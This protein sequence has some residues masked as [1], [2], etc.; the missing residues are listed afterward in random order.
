MMA[1][2]AALSVWVVV[3]VVLGAGLCFAADADKANKDSPGQVE[4]KALFE[5]PV[6][7]CDQEGKTILT[8]RAVGHP[9]VV[10]FNGDGRNDILLGCHKG[11]DTAAAEILVLENVG[12]KH[13]PKFRWPTGK[14]I[15][16][17]GQR[18]GFSVSC[19]CK[20]GG[21]F[22]LHPVDW[23]GDGHFDLVVN[24]Y[25]RS[26]G[27][28]VLRNTGRS[29]KDPTF[30]R[31]E[32]LH[33]IG[34]HGKCS[35]GGDWNNDGIVDF[36]FPVNRY[37]W[38]VYLG[39]RGPGGQ[40][41]FADKPA[42]SHRQYKMIGRDRWFEYSP[43]AWNYSGKSPVGAKTVEIIAVSDDPANRGKP[44]QDQVSHLD[45]Y[46]LD[47][48]AK[49][50]SRVGRLWTNPAAYTRMSIGDLNADGC[51]D[52]LCT[53]GVFT[54]G[55]E[56]KIWVLYGKVRNTPAHAKPAAASSA[57]AAGVSAAPRAAAQPPQSK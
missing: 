47:H 31:G 20:S 37:G 11:M 8:K 38:Q 16:L 28:R 36:A 6:A 19:G 22:E 27:V 53:G 48:N 45:L 24:T 46:V 51:M 54:R 21:T 32:M 42:F 43:Y 56:T 25:W 57:K 29:R 17:E 13:R 18:R 41:R 10:D 3:R 33:R 35:G 4:L 34:S 49:T 1:R 30:V 9:V 26:D 50:V 23:N 12:T 2:S 55:Q 52:L 7:I 14:S 44:L 39:I 40:L 15:R 5:K